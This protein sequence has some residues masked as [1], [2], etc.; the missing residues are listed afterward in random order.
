MRFAT[1][2]AMIAEMYDALRSAGADEEKARKAAEAVARTHADSQQNKSDLRREM[3]S[4]DSGLRTGMHSLG[5]ALRSE[6]QAIRVELATSKWMNAGLLAVA[7]A[8]FVGM[9]FG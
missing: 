8:I 4:L 3:Q 9:L 1:M 7:V 6:M 2:T 5:A